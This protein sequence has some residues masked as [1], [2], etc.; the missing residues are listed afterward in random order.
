[1][2]L[3]VRFVSPASFED[4]PFSH[5][6]PKIQWKRF[7]QPPWLTIYHFVEVFSLLMIYAFL[8]T[9]TI[10]YYYMHRQVFV[11]AFYPDYEYEDTPISTIGEIIDYFDAV[12]ESLND[13]LTD[14]FMKINIS[15]PYEILYKIEWRNG[16]FSEWENEYEEIDQEF[17]MH[18]KSITLSLD[19]ITISNEPGT[20]GCSRW[21]VQSEIYSKEGQSVFSII[22]SIKRSHCPIEILILDRAPEPRLL[23][24]T[25]PK[26]TQHSNLRFE[27]SRP[28]PI[29]RY[30]RKAKTNALKK[31]SY[32]YERKTRPAGRK[33]QNRMPIAPAAI[34]PTFHRLELPM[35]RISFEYSIRLTMIACVHFVFLCIRIWKD[36]RV[37]MS[38][39]KT[40]PD[41][42]HLPTLQQYHFSIGY[43]K[44]ID[45][46]STVMVIAAS[47]YLW[48][49]CSLMTQF[50]SQAAIEVL[51]VATMLSVIRFSQ[52]FGSYLPFYQL[53]VIIREAMLRLIALIVSILPIVTGFCLWGIFTFGYIDDSFETFRY[54]VQRMITS[55]MGDSIDDFY[56]IIDDGTELTSWL[57]FIYVSMITAAGMWV[58]FT[59]CIATVS[60]VH[61]T[62]IVKRD[63]YWESSSDSENTRESD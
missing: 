20:R 2:G 39:M 4:T 19:F 42:R 23:S 52:W 44:T 57:C 25:K 61:Q 18:I 34:Q 26:R 45:L 50:P 14:S 22:P 37:H 32:K 40:R 6:G 24:A 13:I 7:Y 49:D 56:I 55:G 51:G 48:H 15:N 27:K 46:L 30:A 10:Y 16:T 36:F 12:Q 8:S 35:W 58:V 41:Y 9:R 53:I 1:M 31:K 43:W 33:P 29:W 38:W 59:S 21:L 47:G 17:F 11:D 5:G 28:L 3:R 62:Q 63:S 54:L 60:Y